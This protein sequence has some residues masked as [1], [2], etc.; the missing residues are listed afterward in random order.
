MKQSRP[1]VRPRFWWQAGFSVAAL[2]LALVT[3]ISRE[4]IELLTGWD[5][6]NGSGILEWVIVAVLGVIAIALGAA[7]RHEWQRATATSG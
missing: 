7:A 5:P 3:V 4:W 1:A 2:V 6:D